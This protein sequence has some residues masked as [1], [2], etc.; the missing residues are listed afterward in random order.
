MGSQQLL[1]PSAQIC[2][3]LAVGSSSPGQLLLTAVVCSPDVFQS[4]LQECPKS[5]G[6]RCLACTICILLEEMGWGLGLVGPTPLPPVPSMGQV[7][8]CSRWGPQGL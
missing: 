2:Q 1:M 3:A 6:C 7:Q 4:I 8:Q 5:G